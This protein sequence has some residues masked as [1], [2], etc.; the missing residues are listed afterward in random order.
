MDFPR[1]HNEEVVPTDGTSHHF[2]P[3]ESAVSQVDE[4]NFHHA[5]R[6]NYVQPEDASPSH[7]SPPM[8][9]TVTRPGTPVSG[10]PLL[11]GCT[12]TLYGTPAELERE[13]DRLPYYAEVSYLWCMK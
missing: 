12:F 1:V 7:D 6:Y 8:T 4:H 9:V 3:V 10:G 11:Y 5:P 13:L 2:M